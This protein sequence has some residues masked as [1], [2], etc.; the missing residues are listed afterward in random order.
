MS[1]FKTISDKI[2]LKMYGAQ[3]VAETDAP[4]L[5]GI[6]RQLAQRAGL[7]MSNINTKSHYY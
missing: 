3:Q 2:V 4:E 1:G 7:P 5:H 6:V